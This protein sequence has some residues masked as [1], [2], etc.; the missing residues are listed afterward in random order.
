[1]WYI[2]IWVIVLKKICFFLL[3]LMYLNSLC[4]K[5]LK[6]LNINKRINVKFK[7]LF[8]MFM[9]MVRYN[10]VVCIFGRIM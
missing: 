10:D 8:I 6:I 1:M 4:V 3:L 5:I 9:Y 7:I 2:V